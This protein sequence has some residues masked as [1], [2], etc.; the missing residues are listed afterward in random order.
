[1]VMTPHCDLTHT[2]PTCSYNSAPEI[3]SCRANKV[4]FKN[5]RKIIHQ[6]FCPLVFQASPQQEMCDAQR[7]I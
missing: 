6:E 1:M 7:R 3:C 4:I 2:A 5:E